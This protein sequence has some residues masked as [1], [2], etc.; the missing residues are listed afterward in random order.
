MTKQQLLDDLKNTY[1]QLRPSEVDGIGVFA[2]KDIPKGCRDMFST[3]HGEWIKISKE[4]VANLPEH[5]RLL[6][7]YYCV[8]DT[9]FYYIEQSGF[10]KMDLANFINHS[11]TPNIFPVN[12]GE[13][14]EAIRNIK[15]G[16]E[17][18]INYSDC[19]DDL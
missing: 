14:F 3:D 9:Q 17:L 5:T 19:T 15:A 7:S 12:N 10:K 16:E 13:F 11:D 6:V 1:L 18:F 8:S 2:I 4:E